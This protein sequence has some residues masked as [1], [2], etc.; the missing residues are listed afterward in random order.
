M[1]RRWSALWLL[2]GWALLQTGVSQT[3]DFPIVSETA[4]KAELP[5]LFNVQ[6]LSSK[7]LPELSGKQFIIEYPS[8]F[9][10]PFPTNNR[11]RAWWMVPDGVERFPVVVLLHSW[12]VQQPVLE[13]E[14][15]HELLRN[16]I[17]VLMLTLPYHMSRTPS[18]RRSGEV[19]VSG[20]SA[21]LRDS[22]TQ[23][24]WD[25]RRAIDWLQRDPSVDSSKIGLM[26][27]SLGAIVSATTLGNE[28]RIHSAV[29]V[30][31]G[32]DLAHILWNSALT[33][34]ARI[35][36]RRQ[37]YSLNRLRE[38]LQPIEPLNHLTPELGSKTFVIGARHDIIVPWEDTQKLIRAL[39]EPQVLWL[40]TGHFGGALVQRSLFR[41]IRRYFVS[42]FESGTAE[43]PDNLIA[44]TLRIGLIYNEERDTRLAL[45]TDFWR[46]N[47]R[48]TVF[49]SG[50]LTPKGGSLFAGVSLRWGFSLGIEFTPKRAKPSVFWHF[51]L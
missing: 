37:G 42:R 2:I 35:S 16:K 17:G 45:G 15:A 46:S 12:G 6:Y 44:P 43:T 9:V 31:G 47:S 34:Q 26:G 41:V 49:V 5:Q 25:V 28:P 29:L 18:G 39:G 11:V 36:F 40:D 20:D 27:I 48:G 22:M 32:A 23:A 1:R 50:I 13:M 19:M 51:V 10:S 21:R 4:L 33:I 24:V 38:E 7:P 8:A 3:S 30:L 14:V